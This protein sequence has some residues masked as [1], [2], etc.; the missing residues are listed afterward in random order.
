VV[1]CSGSVSF[2]LPPARRGVDALRGFLAVAVVAD[3]ESAGLEADP[4]ALAR[5]VT[6]LLSNAILYNRPSWQVTLSVVAE[7][8]AVRLTVADT[9]LGIPEEDL[10]RVFVRFFRVEKARSRES[11]GSGLGLAICKSL[12]DAHGG[13]IAVTSRVGKGT[14]VAVRLPRTARAARAAR[15][16]NR[17]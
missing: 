15:A 8:D 3:P 16:V 7:G 14:Q 1:S 12:V 11:G 17:R 6:N 4:D 9:G 13:T 2:R 10:P 5:V